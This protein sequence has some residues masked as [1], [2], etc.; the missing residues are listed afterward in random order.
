VEGK[1]VVEAFP[2]S[3]MAAHYKALAKL[4]LAEGDSP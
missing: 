3:D 1:T 2:D 4:L